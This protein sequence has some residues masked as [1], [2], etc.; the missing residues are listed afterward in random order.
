VT[1]TGWLD[2][3]L[4]HQALTQ[5]DLSFVHMSFSHE[6]R[7]VAMTSFPTRVGSYIQAQRPLISLAPHYAS[8]TH[9]IEENHC[10]I[11]HTELTATDLA[12]KIEYLVFGEGVYEDAQSNMLN[13]VSRYNHNLMFQI[14]EQM[15]STTMRKK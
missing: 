5:F 3:H 7:L 2:G 4:F 8:I 15:L 10:G 1:V 6:E 14:F 11:T 13:L 9:F 12:N